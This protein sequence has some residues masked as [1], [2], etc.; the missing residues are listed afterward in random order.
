MG[1]G[2]AYGRQMWRAQPAIAHRADGVAEGR[3]RAALKDVRPG[4]I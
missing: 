1:E 3:A 2:A 4:G